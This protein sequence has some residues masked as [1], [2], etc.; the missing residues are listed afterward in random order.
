MRSLA[1]LIFILL[2]TTACGGGDPAT[3][4]APAGRTPT[5]AKLTGQLDPTFGIEGKVTTDLGSGIEEIHALVVQPDGKIVA[6][7]SSWPGLGPHF[8]LARYTTDGSLDPSFGDGGTVVT[9]LIGDEHD[10]AS[11]RALLQQPDG[12]LVAVGDA[13]QP[14]LGHSV[15]ALARYNADGTLDMTFGDGGKVLAA[16][17]REPSISREDEGHAAALAPD[18]KIVVGGVSGLYPQD[19]ALMRFNADG[20][21]DTTFGTDGRVTTDFGASDTIQ[22][23][24]VLPDGKILAAGYGGTEEGN[25][26]EDFALARYN[27]DG[28]LDSGFGKGGTVLTDVSTNRDEAAALVVRPNGKIVVGGPAYVGVTLCATDACRYFGYAL[29]Q[30]NPDGSLDKSFGQG[31]TAMQ[32]FALSSADYALQL[33]SDGTLAAVG[34]MNDNDFGL[35]LFTPNGSLIDTLGKKGKLIAR[36]GPYRDTAYAVALQPDGKLVIAGT[37]TVDPQDILNGDFALA[38]F[39]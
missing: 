6:A 11:A 10:Y 12:K 8:T 5:T 29:A 9:N 33:L 39:R 7:G 3:P 36:F 24:A 38:R 4:Q 16:V 32:D 25:E 17:D 13:Y 22:G 37:A 28:S 19:F 14:D 30:Y 18:G 1:L 20:S 21:V 31:G 26:N 34:Y 15:F 2:A 27:V 35:A 23:V